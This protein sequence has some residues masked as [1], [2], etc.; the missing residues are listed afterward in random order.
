MLLV[1]LCEFYSDSH[2]KPHV[3]SRR[4]I[5]PAYLKTVSL[6]TTEKLSRPRIKRPV[7]K[8]TKPVGFC[9]QIQ[10]VSKVN[11]GIMPAW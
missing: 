8:V 9:S 2:G 5:A 4:R 3:S 11:R 10:F 7:P 6:I 1:F